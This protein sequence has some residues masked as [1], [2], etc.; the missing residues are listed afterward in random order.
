[1]TQATIDERHL[2][3]LDTIVRDIGNHVNILDIKLTVGLAL[4]IDL[5][6]ELH[7]V[8]VE[9]LTHLLHRPDI[10]EELSAQV[11]VAH[12]RLLDGDKVG[13]DEFDDLVLRRDTLRGH[14]VELLRQPLQLRLYD[15]IVDILLTAEVGVEDTAPLNLHH[16][17]VV[18]RRT[19]EA[20]LSKE[21]TGHVN[22]FLSCL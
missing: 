8:L 16:S 4:G 6:E 11:T 1:M 20:V 22:E 17:Y 5:A 12:H 14:L 21:L 2:K 15:G 13:I 7:L 3:T 19:I 18:H 10:P 9:V